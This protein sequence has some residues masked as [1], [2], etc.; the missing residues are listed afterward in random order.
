MTFWQPIRTFDADKE[1]LTLLHM[2]KSEVEKR[3]EKAQRDVEKKSDRL[4]K[5]D[6]YNS[7]RKK[8]STAR[9]ALALACEERDRWDRRLQ[10]VDEWIKEMKRCV[11]SE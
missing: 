5:M 6:I 11:L 2:L 9:T 4:R 3:L 10:L 7:T 8:R 1:K